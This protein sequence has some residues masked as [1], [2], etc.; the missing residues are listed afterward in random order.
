[1]DMQLINKCWTENC[2][3]HQFA[4]FD[5]K[6]HCME[7]WLGM[8]TFYARLPHPPVVLHDPG[9][10]NKSLFQTLIVTGKHSCPIW[11]FYVF[12]VYKLDVSTVWN[13]VDEWWYLYFENVILLLY[14]DHLSR[15]IHFCEFRSPSVK[16][17]FFYKL[18]TYLVGPRLL[19]QIKRSIYNGGFYST[20]IK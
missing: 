11:L 15:L 3:S 10:F 13:L 4:K 6:H 19:C 2:T 9:L 16:F 5:K 7:R 12:Y 1:M 20:E 8:C 14:F 17:F 18:G